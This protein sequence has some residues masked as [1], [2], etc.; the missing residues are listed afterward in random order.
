MIGSFFFWKSNPRGGRIMSL[1]LAVLA[2]FMFGPKAIQGVLYP[3]GL[4]AGLSVLLIILLGS[5]HMMSNK[6]KTAQ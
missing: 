2:L 4:M 6:S 1:V 5:G 3:S